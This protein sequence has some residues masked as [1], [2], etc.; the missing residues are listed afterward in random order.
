MISTSHRTSMTNKHWCK[1]LDSLSV[2]PRRRIHSGRVSRCCSSKQTDWVLKWIYVRL[3][4]VRS[5][6]R[7]IMLL[8][9]SDTWTPT[10]GAA[11]F[12][13]IIWCRSRR[14]VVVSYY[15]LAARITYSWHRDERINSLWGA[16]V[17]DL[18]RQ[19]DRWSEW[20]ARDNK[21]IVIIL[22][23]QE[24]RRTEFNTKL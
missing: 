12:I 19:P 22:H 15:K 7:M 2:L 18:T 21:I 8:Y 4:Y 14:V 9:L 5:A 11:V 20:R 10:H 24:P 13:C 16:A 3:S 1:L 23:R 17:R 6:V